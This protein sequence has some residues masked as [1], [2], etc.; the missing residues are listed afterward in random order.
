MSHGLFSFGVLLF[1]F[2]VLQFLPSIIFILTAH[3]ISLLYL[4][5]GD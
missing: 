4:H 2:L 3:L 1:P 5:Y